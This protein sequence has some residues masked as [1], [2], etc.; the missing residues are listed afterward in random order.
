MGNTTNKDFN[1]VKAEALYLSYNRARQPDKTE[2]ISELIRY[3]YFFGETSIV[4]CKLSL[5]RCYQKRTVQSVLEDLCHYK[6]VSFYSQTDYGHDGAGNATYSVITFTTA[7][8][9]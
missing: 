2:F 4:N 9:S 7:E 5:S 6:I 3:Q 8:G 1:L